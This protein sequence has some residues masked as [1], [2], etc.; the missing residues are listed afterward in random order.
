MNNLASKLV[1]KYDK[2]KNKKCLTPITYMEL[3][4]MVVNFRKYL[5]KKGIKKNQKILVLTPMSIELYVTLISLWSIGAI[6]CFM[7]AGFIKN[8]IDN[9]NF[10]DIDG[11]IGNTKY[12]MYTCT[13]KKLRNLKNKIN[14]SKIVNEKTEEKL[15][16]KE[17]DEE[18]PAIY[19]YTSGT[20]GKPKIISRSH[21][22][23]L[24]QA[25]ILSFELNY[26][27]EDIE[28]SSVPIF[29]LSNIYA[30]ITTVIA[31]C[32]FSNLAESNPKKIVEQ[33][34]MEK[35]NRIMAAPG[36]LNVITNYCINKDI[37]L[38]QIKK[39]FCGGGAV[40][41]DFIEKLKDVFPNAEITTLYGSSEAE[42]IASLKISDM[43]KSDIKSTQNGSGILAGR[44]AGVSDCRIIKTGIEKI[45]EISREELNNLQTEVGEIVVTGENV[46]KEYVNGIG[47]EENKFT[48]DG[49]T[50]HRTGDMGTFDK[51]GRLWLRG[52]IKEPYFDIEA[53]LHSKFKIEKTAVLKDNED[54]IILI[55]ESNC[56]V[57]EKAIKK[58]I[59]FANINK[60]IYV[61]RIPVDKRHSTK[62]DY[63]QLRELLKIND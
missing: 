60:I 59:K 32:I 58:A 41:L 10:D 56:D 6:P 49:I 63:K 8:N 1:E 57:D 21:S 20:T 18:F 47:N 43:T 2:L 7:D 39:I 33:I 30:G 37:K 44:I 45:G 31:D 11:I 48:V 62:V 5:V 4:Y 46:L 40:F 13:N 16:I 55:L 17:V 34:K 15:E 38:R 27:D 14:T 26:E 19:T 23:L 51:K 53:A 36:L 52:R 29:T 25:R 3:Y 24:N 9:N 50:Y 61:N 22:F 35:V 54:K 12:L 28:L 42:P